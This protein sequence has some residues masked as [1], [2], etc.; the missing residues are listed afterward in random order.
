MYPGGIGYKL[1]ACK[2]FFPAR[3]VAIKIKRESKRHQHHRWTPEPV[4]FH[5]Q[6][7]RSKLVISAFGWGE[8]CLESLRRS[9]G[10]AFAMPDISIIETWPNIYRETYIALPWDFE[11]VNEI[12]DDALM[13]PQDLVAM[14]DTAQQGCLQ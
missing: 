10:A 1:F 5:R 4:E 13:R 2:R 14:A 8:V 9:A 12:L 7:T 3:A 11:T 6:M